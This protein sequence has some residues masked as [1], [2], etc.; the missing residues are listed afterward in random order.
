MLTHFSILDRVQKLAERLKLSTVEYRAE[1]K[2]RD[3]RI[4]FSSKFL[5]R[6]SAGCRVVKINAFY[7]HERSPGRLSDVIVQ[8]R[9]YSYF[10][11]P[12]IEKVKNLS[13]F[14]QPSYLLI[15]KCCK[16]VKKNYFKYYS[17]SI[18]FFFVSIVNSCDYSFN[19]QLKKTK[20]SKN[21]PGIVL[22]KYW[23]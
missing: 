21:C 7:S 22:G 16:L 4:Y 5:F 19:T 18:K 9:A 17:T 11:K 12:E 23:Q 3:W 6:N 15:G 8:G 10:T 14:L 20:N 2:I 1:R 13:P